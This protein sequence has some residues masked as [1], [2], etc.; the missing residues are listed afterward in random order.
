MSQ[1]EKLGAAFSQLRTGNFVET[2]R[3]C[4]QFLATSPE[5]ASFLCLAGQASI[6]LRQFDN[7]EKY[8]DDA[9]RV[10]PD[11]APAF[12]V[13][14]DLM[15]LKGDPGRAC[16]SYK[17]AMRLDP[18]RN[19]T[20]EKLERSRQL[21]KAA[22][23]AKP[24]AA[25]RKPFE[26]ELRKAVAFETNG[27]L[28]SAEMIYREILTREPNHVEA[29]RLLAGIAVHHKRYRDAEVFL[30]KVLEIAPDHAR[31]WLDL[32]NVQRELDQLDDAVE[33][34]R[35]VL[36]LAPD[37][38]ESYMAY[39]GA[40][41]MTGAH[42]EAI[43]AYQRAIAMAPE[44]AGAMCAMAH[45]QKTVGHQNDAIASYRRAIAIKPD[46]AEAYWSLANLKTFRFEDEEVA[47]MQALLRDESLPDVS[48]AQ[49]HNALGL[50]LESRKDYDAAFQNFAACNKIQRLSESY[51]PVETETTYDRIIDLFDADFFAK[52]AG[53]PASEITPVLV[54][55][56]PRSGSTLIEQILAS[57]SQ[58]DGTHELGDLTRAV[59][60]V[61][62]G[63]NRRARFPD[64]LAELTPADWQGIAD[65]YLQRTEIFRSGA[66]FFIDKNPNNFVY[67]GVMKLAFPNARIINARRHPL[68]SCFGSFKQ[69]FASGQ[70]F[71][72][73]MIELGEYYLQYQRLMNHWHAVLPGF[74]LDV[75]YEDVVADLDSQVARL[76][77]YC[78]LPFEEACLRFH[79]TNRAVKTAS[80]E[81]VRRPIYSSS[82]NLWRNYEDHLDE[83][84]QIL[85]PILPD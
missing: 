53:A 5:D 61:R 39:A 43:E 8:I 66:P 62:R 59:Q 4:E 77:D 84:I 70:P 38:A 36:R 82:V 12:E 75:Q 11:F 33:S 45:H 71:T 44:K 55:G 81:Q 57:H 13:H 6:A 9:I 72:Y 47:A 58:V 20:H 16:A 79:E 23:T 25:T 76:L 34:A 2:L 15:L 52:N 27:D 10:S 78:G 35:Q 19:L 65:E 7:A 30:K 26:D 24:A 3:L 29:A 68:D 28:Q 74:V 54:V 64:T 50:E 69:L 22:A 73:D 56:L 83:L 41:G 51:D 32:A 48:R 1:N 17:V 31:A 18:G 80:S 63:K 49:L 14:G 46:H 85:Q 60:S 67:V 40:I 21:E 42:E 37:N